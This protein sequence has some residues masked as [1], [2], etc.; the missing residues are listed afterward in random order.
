MFNQL[1]N[2][3]KNKNNIQTKIIEKSL[4]DDSTWK[5]LIDI[6]EKNM[7]KDDV[8]R[9]DRLVT[10]QKV[11]EIAAQSSIDNVCNVYLCKN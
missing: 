4:K 1:L 5:I 2:I 9:Q 11:S 3:V 10:E 6:A 7:K 8:I